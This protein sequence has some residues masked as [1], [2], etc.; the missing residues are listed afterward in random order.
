MGLKKNKENKW[1]QSARSLNL[2]AVGA[3]PKDSIILS[4][5]LREYLIRSCKKELPNEACGFIS[6][7]NNICSKIWPTTNVNPSP[8][9]FA[10][11][12]NEESKIVN[13][14]NK[15]NEDLIAVYH[16][17]PNGIAIPSKDDILF[18]PDSEIHYFIISI[19]LSRAVVKC[20]KIAEG[21]VS[22]VKVAQG[23]LF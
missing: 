12:I 17:H 6:G 13:E 15:R 5:E 19:S 22:E 1:K 3:T 2:K 18:A 21:S 11:D 10:I 9:T 23:E 8:F 16:S 14:I 7:K 20:Y 4:N